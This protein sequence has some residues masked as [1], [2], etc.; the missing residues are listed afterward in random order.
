M[1]DSL[2]LGRIA[3]VRVGVNWSLVL[4][5]G[6]LA[7]GLA[8]N[9]LQVDA[10]GYATAAY[11]AVAILTSVSL[12]AGVL[13]HELGHAMV[14]RHHGLAVD[15]ITLWFMG[16]V[17]RIEGEPATP[18]AEARVS[19][20]GPVVSLAVGGL[21]WLARFGLAHLAGHALALS[22]LGWLAL[23]NV[24]LAV[25]NLLPA[26]PLDGGRI[27]H[28]AVWAVTGDRLRA[29]RLASQAGVAL[30]ALLAVAGA[31]SLR[32]AGG[33][34]DAGL[35]FVL[36]W[37]TYVSARAEGRHAEASH[38]LD[39]VTVADLMRPV[40]AAPGWWTA[41]ALVGGFA[42]DP[43]S[44]LMLE[45]WTGGFGGVVAVETLAALSPADRSRTRGNDVAVP[46]SATRG[47]S[48]GDNALEALAGQ[49]GCLA[50]LAIDR[51]RTVGAVLTADVESW[52]RQGRRP[53]PHRL[54]PAAGAGVS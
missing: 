26:S 19:G 34:L 29:S 12:L 20:V 21:A 14:A 52:V 7:V 3:G 28:S 25:F 54:Q 18:G 49:P 38:L 32:R 47:A 42:G 4:M 5:V 53:P 48:P 2:R 36:A 9:R 6:L 1:T 16:G 39:G 37:F 41:R 24:A 11:W 15:G 44:V 31:L 43:R 45:E 51:D 8:D 46:I 10:P 33:G 40:A 17:T 27:L 23:I 35:F 22:A 50:V 13:L 30:A